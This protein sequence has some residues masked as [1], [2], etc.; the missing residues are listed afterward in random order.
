M[1]WKLV[2]YINGLVQDCSNS[3][4]N[5]LELLPSCTKPLIYASLS[6]AVICSGPVFYLRMC[7]VSG[8]ERRHYICENGTCHLENGSS[9]IMKS[10]LLYTNDFH[11][12]IHSSLLFINDMAFSPSGHYL[13]DSSS[14][15]SLKVIR[16]WSPIDFIIWYLIFNTLRLRQNCRHIP[17]VTFKWIFL[18]GNVCIS[19]KI[20]LKSVPEGL[21]NNIPAMVHIM[22]W[23]QPGDKPLFEPLMVSLLTQKFITRPQW[24]NE[25]QWLDKNE[26]V[27][28]W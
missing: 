23:H 6:W 8:N 21:I 3:I 15:M 16:K 7:K 22:A 20:S 2:I 5:A 1:D 24:V 13:H 11:L 28:G 26:R 17:D 9:M 25:C 18:N 12:Q 14:F 27:A 4:A 10:T 19:I